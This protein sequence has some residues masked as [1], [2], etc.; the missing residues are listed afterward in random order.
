MLTSGTAYI[1]S[2][3]ARDRGPN[4]PFPPP[5]LYIAAFLIAMLLDA[6]VRE[7]SFFGPSGAPLWAQIAGMVA[8]VLGVALAT[9][10]SIVF[11]I[12][13][14][15]I[16]PMFPATTL[17]T[18]GPYRFTRNPMY[19]GMT[20]GYVGLAV[21]LNTVWPLILL[22]LVLYLLIRFVVRR[23][24]AHLTEKFGE[25]YEAYRRRVRRWV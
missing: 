9:W 15:P 16:I 21:T 14:T 23:E 17:V 11:R 19:V 10:G 12:A 6:S 7:I 2:T 24:E 18:D 8:L 5:I 25:A 1:L 22:P 3:M 20:V 4:A 13:M